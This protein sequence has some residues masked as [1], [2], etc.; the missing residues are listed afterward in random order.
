MTSRFQRGLATPFRGFKHLRAHPHLW[1]FVIPAALVNVLITGA[2]LVVLVLVA[3]ALVAWVH[4]MFGEGVW[5]VVLEV[6]VIVAVVLVVLALTLICWMLMQNIIA[7]HLLSKLAER[8]ERDL[9]IDDGEIASVPFRRQVIDGGL[10]TGLLLTINTAGFLI[11]LIP[12]IGTVIGVPLVFIGDAWVLGSDFLAHPLNL[13]GQTFTQRQTYLRKHAHET[14]GIGAVVAP[15]G[16]IPV[17]GGLVTA[18][19]VIGA[20]LLYRELEEEPASP[21]DPNA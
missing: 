3:F 12:G 10:D 17:V 20:V 2:A 8:V 1:P 9:G 7:G 11:Q 21:R 4:P 16:L 13:R 19:A 14:V 18:C 6:I 15:L 5:A